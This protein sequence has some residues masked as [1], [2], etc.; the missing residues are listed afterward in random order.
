MPLIHVEAR[1]VYVEAIR[2]SHSNYLSEMIAGDAVWSYAPRH[3]DY[4]SAVSGVGET[5]AA[6]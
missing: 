6:R 3:P 5:A 4:F 2:F 1:V